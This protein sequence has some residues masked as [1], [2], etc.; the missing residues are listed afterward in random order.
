M[1][2]LLQFKRGVE[3]EE[4]EANFKLVSQIMKAADELRDEP[5]EPKEGKD[6][7]YLR[8]LF[9]LKALEHIFTYLTICLN[10]QD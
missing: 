1:G 8:S 2:K 4:I 5:R 3:L 6:D 7:E 9:I 10:N